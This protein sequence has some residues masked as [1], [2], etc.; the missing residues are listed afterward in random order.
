MYA[1]YLKHLVMMKAAVAYLIRFGG[2]KYVPKNIVKDICA[3]LNQIQRDVTLL[4]KHIQQV[5]I[6]HS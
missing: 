2:P 1:N 4:E 3:A 5:S 6:I